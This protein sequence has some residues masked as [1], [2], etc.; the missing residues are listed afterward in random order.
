MSRSWE[1]RVSEYVNSPRLKHRLK[2]GNRLSC[3]VLG[4]FG[5]YRTEASTGARGAASCNCPSDGFPC[6]HVAALRETYRLRPRSFIDIVSIL[7]GLE[8]KESK[9]LAGLIRKMVRYAPE[10]LYVLGV[11]GFEREDEDVEYD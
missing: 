5:T 4:N 9:E 2:A 8:K 1:D 11:K 3:T 6:K 7:K 10:A